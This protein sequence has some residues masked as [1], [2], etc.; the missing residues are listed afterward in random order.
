M[1]RIVYFIGT[2]HIPTPY[3]SVCEATEIYPGKN[4]LGV[5][6][7]DVVCTLLIFCCDYSCAVM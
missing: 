3:Q 6:P 7:N 2:G 5:Y 1:T 4:N